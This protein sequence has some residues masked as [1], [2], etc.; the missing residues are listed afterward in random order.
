MSDAHKRKKQFRWLCAVLQFVFSIAV[1]VAYEVLRRACYGQSWIDLG[2]GL[3]TLMRDP[4][5]ALATRI[6][7]W[8][9]LSRETHFEM[10]WPDARTPQHGPVAFRAFR[11]SSNRRW[12]MLVLCGLC[13]ALV[14]LIYFAPPEPGLAQEDVAMASVLGAC[15]LIS[16]GLFVFYSRPALHLDA[17][18][19]RQLCGP[20]VAWKSIGAC[21]VEIKRD[22]VGEVCH[23]SMHALGEAGSAGGAA[24]RLAL[25]DLRGLDR[26]Q[27]RIFLLVLHRALQPGHDAYEI[28]QLIAQVLG[29]EP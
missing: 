25:F 8:R 1:V 12:P 27:Q 11:F 15:A 2:G 9:G 16:L 10:D 17:W 13:L 19:I 4:A 28:A 29:D 23:V 3:F 5:K 14:G 18:G 21:R 22:V 24:R 7:R 6:F 20:Q 26:P